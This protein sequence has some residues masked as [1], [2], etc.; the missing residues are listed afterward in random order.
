MEPLDFQ[1]LPLDTFSSI[2]IHYW[3]FNLTPIL[4]P[5]Q[6]GDGLGILHYRDRTRD[7]LEDAFEFASA[8]GYWA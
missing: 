8:T 1:L 4:G 5:P 7:A 3:L 6:I 2:G